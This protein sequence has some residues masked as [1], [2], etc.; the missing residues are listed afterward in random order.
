VVITVRPVLRVEFREIGSGDDVDT[1]THIPVSGPAEFIAGSGVVSGGIEANGGFA[2]V[3]GDSFKIYVRAENREA[4]NN[5]GAGHTKVHRNSGWNQHAGRDKIVLLGYQAD[6]DRAVRIA[7]GAKVI[8]H[9]FAAEVEREGIKLVAE[10]QVFLGA[11]GDLQ[12]KADTKP[13]YSDGYKDKQEFD[14]LA[15]HLSCGFA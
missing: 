15:T 5:I 9:E 12:R 14:S 7:S 10:A 4:V 11:F 3:A 13:A 1:G 8:L 6:G 2:D